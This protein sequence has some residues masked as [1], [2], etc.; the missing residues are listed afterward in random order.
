METILN[1]LTLYIG[2]LNVVLLLVTP[3][4]P[5]L[6]KDFIKIT[7]MFSVHLVMFLTS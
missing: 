6:R 3:V 5:G 7:L 2:Y 4:K 1:R